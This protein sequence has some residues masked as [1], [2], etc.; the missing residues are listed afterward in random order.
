MHDQTEKQMMTEDKTP[1]LTPTQTPSEAFDDA[2]KAVARLEAL[3]DE[4]TAFLVTEF[5]RAVQAGK[6]AA[7]IRAYYPEI[8]LTVTS[9]AKVDSRL[10]FGHVSG[11]GTYSTTVTRPDMF[12]AYLTSRSRF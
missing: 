8:R 9:H 7:R 6:P 12:R 3:Y 5:S 10:S 1:P 11:P 2:A 4:A